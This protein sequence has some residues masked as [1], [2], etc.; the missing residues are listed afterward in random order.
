MEKA[1]RVAAHVGIAVVGVHVLDTHVIGI[2]SIPE[3]S[4][5]Q[6]VETID[7]SLAQSLQL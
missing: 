5:G 3:G 2:T 7:A 1:D 6:L 4:Q